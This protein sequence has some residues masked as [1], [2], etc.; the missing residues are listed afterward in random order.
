[1]QSTSFYA[2]WTALPHNRRAYA[3]NLAELLFMLDLW[4]VALIVAPEHLPYHLNAYRALL[5]G[6]RPDELF[7]TMTPVQ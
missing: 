4:N 7:L 2:G 6:E 3:S 1:M 5:A